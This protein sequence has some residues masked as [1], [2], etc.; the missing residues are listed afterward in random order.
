MRNSLL[1]FFLTYGWA[2]FVVIL[3]IGALWYFNIV[4]PNAF[5]IIT[6]EQRLIEHC[7]IE[8]QKCVGVNGTG[9]NI[10]VMT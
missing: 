5:H 7:A 2:V 9:F 1:D 3:S 8:V 6:P 10:S 4:S